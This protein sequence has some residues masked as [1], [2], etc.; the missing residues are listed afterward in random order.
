MHT[1]SNF[2]VFPAIDLRAGKVVRLSQGDPQ[3]QTTYSNDLCWWANR[4]LSEGADWVHVINLNGAFG[5]DSHLNY[6]ALHSLIKVGMKVEFGGGIRDRACINTILDA[7]VDRV[8]LGTAAITNPDLVLWAIKSY[9][10][11]RIAGDIALKDNNVFIKGWQETTSMSVN[12]AGKFF[13]N[14]GL[15]RCV[16]TNVK[17]D[18][19]GNGID[20]TGAVE[21]QN[22]SG[23]AI[24]ASGGVRCLADVIHAKQAGLAGIIIGRALYEGNISLAESIKATQETFPKNS[25]LDNQTT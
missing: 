2:C 22:I 24:V 14:L 13:R 12:D 6:K 4:W 23:L 20:L 5:E 11:D 21:L 10:P 9:G 16:F 3:K 25:L 15:E 19:S 8:F 18:G 1:P 7:G 17:Q